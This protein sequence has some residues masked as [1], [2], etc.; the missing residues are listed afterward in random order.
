MGQLE[1]GKNRGNLLCL[2]GRL[3]PWERWMKNMWAYTRS[4]TAKSTQ[5][6]QSKIAR[7]FRDLEVCVLGI[8]GV[9]YGACKCV[10][11]SFVVCDL[12][13]G[14]VWIGLGFSSTKPYGPVE[15]NDPDPI[16]NQMLQQWKFRKFQ[17]RLQTQELNYQVLKPTLL[18][19]NPKP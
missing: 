7:K 5:Q 11:W 9:W 19:L 4:G 15:F 3:Q 14:G 6:M 1:E 16:P 17:Y 10:I 8:L 12:W 2:A 13:P 18:Y